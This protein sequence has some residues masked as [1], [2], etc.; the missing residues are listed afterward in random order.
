MGKLFANSGDPDQMPGS[1]LGLH[2]MS[3][4]LLE[5]S[6][7]KWVK[8]NREKAVQKESQLQTCSLPMTSTGRVNKL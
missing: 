3:V 2:C 1:D 8:L 6:R 4:N 7:L 5:V